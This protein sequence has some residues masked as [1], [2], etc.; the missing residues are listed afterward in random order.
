MSVKISHSQVR[1]SESYLVRECENFLT[2]MNIDLALLKSKWET[3]EEIHFEHYGDKNRS[4]DLICKKMKKLVKEGPQTGDPHFPDHVRKAKI[5]ANALYC[6]FELAT[7]V[8]MPTDAA[9]DQ[10]KDRKYKETEEAETMDAPED[11]EI[12]VVT[13]RQQSPPSFSSLT[14]SM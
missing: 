12:K 3:M 10:D 13:L 6:K 7:V 5:L 14:S 8:E 4:S 1:R 9:K 2:I 11:K